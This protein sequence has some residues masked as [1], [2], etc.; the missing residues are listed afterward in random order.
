MK[1]FLTLLVAATLSTVALAQTT[2]TF[3]VMVDVTNYVAGGAT[4]ATNGVRVGGTF[5]ALG[6]TS[7]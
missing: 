7:N 1:K 3:T 2:V 6:A 5:G 4:I